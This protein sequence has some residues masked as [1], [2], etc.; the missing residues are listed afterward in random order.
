[1]KIRHTIIA[2]IPVLLL[3]IFASCKKT[4]PSIFNQFPV[5]LN[6]QLTAPNTI[7]EQGEIEIAS[8]DSVIIDYTIE[9]PNEDM[10]IICLYET[11]SNL[12]VQKIPITDNGKRRV[13]SGKFTIKASDIGAGSTTYR[14][15]PL[16]QSGVYLGDGYKKVT[17][18]VVPDMIYLSNRKVFVADTVGKVDPCYLSLKDGKT[19]SYTT[20]A[21]NSN[22]IDL[23]FYQKVVMVSGKPE[24]QMFMYSLSANPL[25][26]VPYDI[27]SWTKRGT[28]FSAPQSGATIDNWRS[29]FNTGPN[30]LREATSSSVKIN[31]TSATA[32]LAGNQYIFFKT[33]EDKY[34]V[35]WVQSITFDY[36]L[37]QYAWLAI[38]M[39]E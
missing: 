29:R 22:S 2:S 16:N 4:A 17:I 33:P 31:L 12:P 8:K 1:M 10:Y 39:P 5:V 25:P 3:V 13:Y 18:H 28:L 30:I 34:G 37:R 26:F 32:K 27:S 15:W 6:Y 14:I 20:G 38:K 7:E 36:Q 24:A 11:G 21:N 9:S 23:G 19:Y 35:I